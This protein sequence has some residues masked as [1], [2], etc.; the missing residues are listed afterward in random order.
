MVVSPI[1]LSSYAL[2]DPLESTENTSDCWSPCT[3]LSLVATVE[4]MSFTILRAPP[5]WIEEGMAM[6]FSLGLVTG[7]FVLDGSF[8]KG[9][10]EPPF[11]VPLD[12]SP[13]RLGDNRF[14]GDT[15]ARRGD[16]LRRG[17]K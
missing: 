15:A 14:S 17:N 10:G 16:V 9:G 13:N 6:S 12:G 3:P 1:L 4:L 7:D 8:G 11:D 5:F 2:N